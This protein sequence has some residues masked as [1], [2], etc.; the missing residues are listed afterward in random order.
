MRPLLALLAGL[1]AASAFATPVHAATGDKVVRIEDYLFKKDRVH[2]RSG[3][4]VTWRFVD[5]NIAHNV[6][7]RS[8]RSGDR[9]TGSFRKRFRKPGTYTYICSFHPSMRGTI[10]VLPRA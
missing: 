1:A 7:G 2:V 3:R 4:F 5:M 6:T 9:R 8:V 10:V